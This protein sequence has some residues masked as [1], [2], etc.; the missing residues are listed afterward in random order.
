MQF[1]ALAT[2]V[3]IGGGLYFQLNLTE[4]ALVSLAVAGVWAAE[5]VNTAIETLTNLVSPDFH[6]LAGKAK[7]VAAG[8]VLLAGFGAVVVGSCVFGP[9]IWALWP[10]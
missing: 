10:R 4:W 2:V 3:V 1:H 9:K 5:L 8:A 6:P 7:D